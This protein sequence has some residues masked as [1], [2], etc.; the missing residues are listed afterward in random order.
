MYC[1]QYAT[2]A[3]TPATCWLS[4]LLQFAQP[5]L[6]CAYAAS[7]QA[8]EISMF[9]ADMQNL[10]QCKIGLTQQLSDEQQRHLQ[11][12][13]D[14]AQTLKQLSDAELELQDS[15]R[16]KVAVALE[17]QLDRHQLYQLNCCCV[18]ATPEP[19]NRQ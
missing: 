12:Q 13:A 5:V 9:A 14:H 15:K 1:D 19:C 4:I 8:Q 10:R 2:Y 7:M 17:Q 16:Y 11:L 18:L 3:C 6:S